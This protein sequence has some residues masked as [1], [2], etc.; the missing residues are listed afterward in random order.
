VIWKVSQV[1]VAL[2]NRAAHQHHTLQLVK[3]RGVAVNGS[4]DVRQRP[5]GNER[6]LARI[7][8]DL[9]EQ[10][11]DGVGMRFQRR[12]GLSPERLRKRYLALRRYALGDRNGGVAGFSEQTID[13]PRAELRVSPGG[14]D[15]ENFELGAGNR[16]TDGEG[17][18]D[19]V[20]DVGVDDDFN[21]RSG[22]GGCRRR[23]LGEEGLRTERHND[24]GAN[25][26]A[27]KRFR[28]GRVFFHFARNADASTANRIVQSRC[29]V[30]K[31]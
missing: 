23:R 29:V 11:I 17:V 8:A 28:E 27:N 6:D 19:V 21:F 2:A 16:K 24:G 30:Y 1:A 7:L 14:A 18:V 25:Q 10:E 3:C 22:A 4:T 5:D 26:K 31:A 13:E 20:A 15:A 9:A 12:A